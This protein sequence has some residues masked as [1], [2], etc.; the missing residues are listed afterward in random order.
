MHLMVV[1]T[2]IEYFQVHTTLVQLQF[3][4]IPISTTISIERGG[5]VQLQ[6]ELSEEDTDTVNLALSFT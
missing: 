1:L 4:S 3:G 2:E 6:I 5:V